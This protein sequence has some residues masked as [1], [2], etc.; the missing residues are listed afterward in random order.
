MNWLCRSGFGVTL[1]AR[2]DSFDL[3][4]PKEMADLGGSRDTNVVRLSWYVLL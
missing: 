2:T 3:G 1:F 4:G